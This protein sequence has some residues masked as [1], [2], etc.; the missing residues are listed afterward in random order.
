MEGGLTQGA[1]TDR[2]FRPRMWL[3]DSLGIE[4]VIICLSFDLG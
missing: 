2:I 3:I 4:K 1:T